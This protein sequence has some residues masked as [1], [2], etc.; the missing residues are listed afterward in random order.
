[1]LAQM[2][3]LGVTLEQ[4]ESALKNY[5]ANTSGG[6]L[7]QSAR[8]YLIRNIG[9]TARLSDLQNLAIASKNNQP[10][11]LKQVAE[12]KLAAAAKRGDASYNA[13]PAVI[14]SVQKQ[15]NAD[16]V[17]LTGDIEAALA[18][19]GKS[20]PAGMVAPQIVFKQ[21]NF[22]EGS[23]TNV[24][25]ALRDGAIMVV[26]VLFLFLLNIQIGRAHV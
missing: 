19:L 1:M 24:E 5:A 23:I 12:V 14:L 21:A 7:E 3:V 22:I 8:E 18:D 6:F 17:K 2:Q 4:L 9:R 16:T 10:I 15:P 26:V 13:K 20:L 11:L 25:E